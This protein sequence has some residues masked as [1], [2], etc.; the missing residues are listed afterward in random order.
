[1][2][3]GDSDIYKIGHT[4]KDVLE[5]MRYIK[6]YIQNIKL[7]AQTSCGVKQEKNLHNFFKSKNIA[8]YGFKEYFQLTPPEVDFIINYFKKINNG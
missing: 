6:F 5:R 4:S 7:I 3:V 2:Q 1:M 8:F